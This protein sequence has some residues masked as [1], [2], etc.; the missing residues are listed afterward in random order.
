MSGGDLVVEQTFQ[1]VTGTLTT[2]EG[3]ATI[4]EGR[5]RGEAIQ[6]VA[7]GTSYTGR[8]Q[9]D[10]MEGIAVAANGTKQSWTA[11]RRK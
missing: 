5:L 10:R 8:V 7:N 6:F 4:T 9:G 1:K 11:Q 2:R 3:A